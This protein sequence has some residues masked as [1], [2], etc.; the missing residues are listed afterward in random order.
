MKNLKPLLFILLIFIKNEI[1]CEEEKKVVDADV[2]EA[3]PCT[4]APEKALEND[5]EINQGIVSYTGAQLWRVPYSNQTYKNAVVQLQ[6]KFKISMWNL[7]NSHVDMFVKQPV[8]QQAKKLLIDSNVPFEV[9]IDDLQKAIDEENPP[10][11]QIVLW[12]NRNGKKYVC[13]LNHLFEV[14]KVFYYYYFYY[15]ASM[16]G[17]IFVF[18]FFNW[19]VG[20]L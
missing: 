10:R 11:E 8:V 18:V 19:K 13:F 7:Q 20:G 6:K 12:Q 5:V 17:G 15:V 9:V 3:G 4:E 14:T 1:N 16:R 2:I